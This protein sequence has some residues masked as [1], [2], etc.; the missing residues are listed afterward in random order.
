NSWY[1]DF[2]WSAGRPGEQA[3]YGVLSGTREF[4]PEHPHPQIGHMPAVPGDLRMS[5]AAGPLTLA[6]GDDAQI[7]VAVAIAAPAAP[8]TSGEVLAPGDPLDSGRAL[9]SVAANLYA[10]MLAAE[11]IQ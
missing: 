11:G 4:G 9:N 8:F 10:R 1:N 7:V 3:G 2:D 5:V 6:P